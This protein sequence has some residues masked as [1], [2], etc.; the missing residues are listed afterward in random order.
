MLLWLTEIKLL[1]KIVCYFKFIGEKEI[2]SMVE[3]DKLE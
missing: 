2:C 3:L 1:L